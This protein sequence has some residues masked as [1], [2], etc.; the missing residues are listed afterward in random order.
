[1]QA[2]RARGRKREQRRAAFDLSMLLSLLS[3][4]MTLFFCKVERGRNSI[5][6]SRGALSA[7]S[8]RVRESAEDAYRVDT[9]VERAD[10]MAGV[11]GRRRKKSFFLEESVRFSE[12]GSLDLLLPSTR[13]HWLFFFSSSLSPARALNFSGFEKKGKKRSREQSTPCALCFLLPRSLFV[14]PKKV[15]ASADDSTL[16]SFF[17]L[18]RPRCQL[19]TRADS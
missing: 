12:A 5:S 15:G 7:V 10:C 2:L 18:R 4:S 14:P 17:S 8:R 1:M 11:A 16:L 3:L 13:W 9:E 19:D 6:L